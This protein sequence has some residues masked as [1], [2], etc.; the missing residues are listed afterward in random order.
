MGSTRTSALIRVIR[1]KIFFFF[2]LRPKAAPWHPRRIL[3]LAAARG[4][5]WT[6]PF[7]W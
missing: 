6:H 7:Y 5:S 1:G 4:F 3:L 2:G